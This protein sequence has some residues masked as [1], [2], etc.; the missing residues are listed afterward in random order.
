ML[1]RPGNGEWGWGGMVQRDRLDHNIW[2]LK[3]CDG[4]LCVLTAGIVNRQF[5]RMRKPCKVS[6]QFISLEVLEDG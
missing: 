4:W 6:C 5:D 3:L 1:T 2:E